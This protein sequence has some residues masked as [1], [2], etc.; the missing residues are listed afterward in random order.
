MFQESIYMKLSINESASKGVM[1]A[2]KQNLPPDGFVAVLTITEN[3]FAGIE[4]LL[5]DFQ[6]DVVHDDSRVVEL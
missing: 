4:I 2:V 3:Q 1:A 5:G 6:T